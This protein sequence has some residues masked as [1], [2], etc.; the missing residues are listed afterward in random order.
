VRDLREAWQNTTAEI[1]A[2]DPDFKKTWQSVVDFR[3][4]FSI[5]EELGLL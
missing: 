4:E 2:V 3:K 1:A 5:W